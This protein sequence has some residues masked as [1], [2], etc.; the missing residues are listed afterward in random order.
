MGKGLMKGSVVLLSLL[1]LLFFI[2]GVS[3][4][5][6]PSWNSQ[7]WGFRR[8]I[9]VNNSSGNTLTDFQ[10]KVVL[11]GSFDFARCKADG[12]DIR[13]TSD[14][15][16]TLIPYWIEE[17]NP[18]G[19]SATVWVKVPNIP[20]AG[21]T[22]YL[23]Y[24][25]PGADFPTA[26]PPASINLPPT[27]P[28][29]NI[30]SVTV[31]GRPGGLL[32]ENMVEEGGN[33][34]QL[35]TDR[36][37]CNGQLG[38]G[39]NT[40]GDP[41][42]A[43]GWNWFGNLSID[44]SNRSTNPAFAGDPRLDNSPG[45]IL[46]PYLDSPHIVK[47]DDG[48]WYVFYHW[49]VG[50]DPHGGYGTPQSLFTT[51]TPTGEF[52]DGPYELGMKFSSAVAG[53]ITKIKYFR[54]SVETGSH[55]GHVW[56]TSG[57]L[58]ATVN[59]A[60]ES[61]YG[62]QEATLSTPLYILPN[63]TYI[64][65]V[66][67]NSGYGAENNFFDSPYNNGQLTGIADGNNGV[68]SETPGN[69]PTTSFN[70]S[71]YF[72]DVVFESISGCGVHG[73]WSWTP[74]S[75]AAIG[76]ARAASITGPYTELDP[77]A[78]KS[79]QLEGDTDAWDWARVSEPY[80]FKRDDGKW[81]MLFMADKGNYDDPGNPNIYYI[82]QC[83]YAIA[84][85]ITGPYT[86]WHNGAEP[87]IAFG[88]PGSLDAGTIAD[89]HPVKFGST[90]YLFY[91][92]S[93]S[94]FGWNTMYCTT[95]DWENITKSTS[96]VY[97]NEGNSPFR[98]AISEFNNTYYFS[99]L[100]SSTSSAGP[101]MICTQPMSGTAPG[102]FIY[103]ADAVFNFY[104]GFNGNALDNSKWNGVDHGYSGTVTVSNGDM[105]IC[106]SGGFL[107]E[108]TAKQSFGVGYIFESRAKHSSYG[109]AGEIGWGRLEPGS[110]WAGPPFGFKNLRIM[111]LR[112]ISGSNFVIDADNADH[113]ESPGDYITTGIPLN[114][115]YMLHSIARVD[116]NNAKFQLDNYPAEI[117]SNTVSRPSRISTDA[118]SP[119]FFILGNSC[120]NVDWVRVRKYAD[121]EPA[122]SIGPEELYHCY[123]DLSI[124]KTVSKNNP[125]NGEDITFTITATNDGP[126]NSAWAQVS[127]VLQS[128]FNYVS[129]STDNGTFNPTTGL[130][131]IGFL[132]VGETATLTITVNV[133]LFTA[134]FD[135]GA[136]SGFN[137]FVLQDI[138]QPSAD[139]QGKVA[140]GRDAHFAGYSVG[141]QLPNSNG[142][143]DVLIVGRNLNYESGGIFGGNV[144]YGNSTNLPQN[145]VSILHGTLRQDSPVDFS[146]ARIYLNNL[147]T[148]LAAYAVNG[149]TSLQW[150]AIT[151]AG[152]DPFLNIFSVSGADLSSANSVII[153]VPNGSVVLVNISG[154]AV[155]WQGGLTVNGTAV[156]N[157]LYNFYEATN[158]TIQGIDLRGSILAPF[159]TVNFVSG[160]QNGQ[161]ICNN[162]FGQGQFNLA[163]FNGNI[164]LPPDIINCAEIVDA[165]Q[166]DRDS[167]PGNGITTEDDYACVDIHVDLT[168]NPSNNG[169]KY[170][171]QF[172]N[173]EIVYSMTYDQAGNILAGT[174]GGKIYKSSNGG[175][176]FTRINNN[177]YVGLIWSLAV[178]SGGNI[179][180][181]T[182]Q[183]VFRSTDNG[184]SW[185]LIGLQYKD[186]RSIVVDHNG[187]IFAGTW[188]FGVF[189]SVD[190]GLTWTS[191]NNNLTYPVVNSLALTS[192]N[193]F[194][195]TY[196]FGLFNTTD[197]SSWTHLNMD[198][199]LI[200]CLGATSTDILF[201]GTYGDG[202]YKSADNGA[203]WTKLA[204]GLNAPFIY[205]IQ[206]D[207]SNNIYV[208]SWTSGVFAS[209]DMG[210]NWTSLGMGGF[211]VSSILISP[212]VNTIYAGTKDGKIYMK[213]NGITG[214]KSE[215]E[216][217]TEFSLKQNY[218]NPFNPSTTIEFGIPE[219][220]RYVIKIYNVIGEVVR[221]LSDKE[222]SAGFH[223]IT[224]NANDLSSGIYFYQ[225]LGEKVK[226][227]QKMLLLK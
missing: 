38:L 135:F 192:T 89:V 27:G 202:L 209:S 18:A 227:T 204:N 68:Y 29:T 20:P 107:T 132:H 198:Y 79:S 32:A 222:L 141:D 103:G 22:I 67:S 224:F 59:F 225:L 125:A 175:T 196:G 139:T 226:L 26:S 134:A 49:I 64:V 54:T 34:W 124:T 109:F 194:A 19:T 41:G 24:D 193:L 145:G 177:M 90:Y 56:S 201:A 150:G 108:V 212:K 95:T 121:P 86:K 112:A 144:V 164:P 60:S 92:A 96:Y 158:I 82:E 31:N 184:S 63:T 146:A 40:S 140:A 91:A 157:V 143:E 74:N 197:A 123:A 66:N 33:Y 191:A 77:F 113:V 162:L 16:Q 174:W 42:N 147:S 39:Q 3:I 155:T 52:T 12:S 178:N 151:L 137:L 4:I 130:W 5:A 81:I 36:N 106:N 17:W 217:P 61:S 69:F 104:D 14:D 148:Q 99:Y 21:T 35:F 15:T 50:G 165:D 156:T 8:A 169:W 55:T 152:S 1:A 118:L 189:K 114:Y 93:P 170:V 44:F 195:A 187:T 206:I 128:G 98:G 154:T 200:W 214:A 23:Y 97:T 30:P 87:F 199:N 88:S 94:T 72:R 182:E 2:S 43:S 102:E 221:I 205:S 218:P 213:T 100:G 11:N 185:D 129:H 127:D 62:W 142:T 105:V 78:L 71:N 111:D 57:A 13:F 28:W 122:L 190:N 160:V 208:S 101:F 117:I 51:Q 179:F 161:M 223:R 6:Q 47:G 131:D 153:N 58:L 171:G 136:A 7:E 186:V 115:D 172:A 149:S 85:N 183:G 168:S 166:D 173:G 159:A 220:G 133:D 75:F 10:V 70:N 216:I 163:L 65:S 84:D 45:N 215:E 73:T 37:F 126:G 9:T 83:S 176:S 219:S 48:F 110:S 120:M 188:G 46:D 167:T 53:R 211:G 25:N 210:N 119:W 116:N 181:G 138:D 80:V 180:A 76:V 207:P 203:S